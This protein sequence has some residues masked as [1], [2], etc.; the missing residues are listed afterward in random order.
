MLSEGLLNYIMLITFLVWLWSSKLRQNDSIVG[1]SSNSL[2][3]LA[4]LAILCGH[5]LLLLLSNNEQFATSSNVLRASAPSQW[6][7]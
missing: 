6:S 1:E 4:W 5:F 2:C 7:T 3:Y